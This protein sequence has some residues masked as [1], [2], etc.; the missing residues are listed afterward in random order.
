MLEPSGTPAE[1]D[2]PIYRAGQR[3]T[4]WGPGGGGFQAQI[5]S[6]QAQIL[7]LGGAGIPDPG[8]SPSYLNTDGTGDRQATVV[9]T[10][11]A[12]GVY[13]GDSVD[14][15]SPRLID[16]N[17]HAN[18]VF[19]PNGSPAGIWIQFEFSVPV[20]ITEIT[21]FQGLNN[22]GTVSHTCGTWQWEASNGSG[23][24]AVSSPVLL[25]HNTTTICDRGPGV[26]RACYVMDLSGN[27]YLWKKY[28]LK[29]VSGTWDHDSDY[30]EEM[31]FKIARA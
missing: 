6:L 11:S 31:E 9:A 24:T 29:C 2:V 28:R 19:Q 5:D 18:L 17:F 14:D 15:H 25:D 3:R 16:G 8:L 21:F 23:W 12:P 27:H 20:I 26:G 30:L 13:E 22:F 10:R 4:E 7:A 1:G